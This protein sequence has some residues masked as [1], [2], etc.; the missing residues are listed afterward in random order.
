MIK[1]FAAYLTNA[2]TNDEYMIVANTPEEAEA[3]SR[4]LK[5]YS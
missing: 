2:E 5:N 3:F 1:Q 4:L